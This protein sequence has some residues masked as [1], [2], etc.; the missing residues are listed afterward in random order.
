[1]LPQLRELEQRIGPEMV[2]I[3]VH[4]AKFL[5]EQAT[6]NLRD[7]VL[8]YG[9]EHP[10]VNDRDF[11]VWNEYAVRAW[12]TLMFIDPAGRVI[13]KHEG[14]APIAALER[15][16]REMLDEF[17]AAGLLD[18][19]RPLPVHEESL[20]T[21]GAL[22]FPGKVAA[23]PMGERL[24]VAD[25]NHDRVLVI[26]QSGRLLRAFGGLSRPQGL[27]F[28]GGRL[29]IAETGAHSVHLAD[30]ET[31]SLR[32]VAGTGSA[33]MSTADLAAGALRSPWDLCVVNG[34]VY[35]AMAG[36]HQIWR[37]D[38]ASGGIEPFAGS[39]REGLRDGPLA[40]A[41]LAQPSGIA[42]GAGAL[43]VADSE[44]SAVRR[45][46]LD[47]REV[48][49]VVGL[50]LFEFGDVDGAGD[51]VRLQHP[52]GVAWWEGGGRVVIAD[53]YNS[54]IK[55]L[56]PERRA[57]TTLAGSAHEF[58]EP[59]GVAVLGDVAYVA[60]TNNHALRGVSLTSGEIGGVELSGT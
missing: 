42:A 17:R 14:E 32:R 24:A 25:T 9:V 8:R 59:G 30:L 47:R 5:A 39:G 34:S 44:V 7:A 29:W 11:A 50:D 35:V 53:S 4:S 12:P 16:V 15:V 37:L 51:E 49:T 57:V 6:E 60:D 58:N 33:A 2:V 3:G 13:A 1:M 54:K 43:W 52:L 19:S 36:S 23:D 48:Q 46:D 10:V 22:A 45:I 56:D 38:A 31:G 28:D 40:D 20:A 26:D 41:W 21:R 27:A 55:L 18:T